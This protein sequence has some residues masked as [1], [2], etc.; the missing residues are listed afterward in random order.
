MLFPSTP[1]QGDVIEAM[2]GHTFTSVTKGNYY[3]DEHGDDDAIF[4]KSPLMDVTFFHEQDCCEQV[5]IKDICGDLEDLE[6][7]PVLM[8]ECIDVQQEWQDG[9]RVTSSWYKFAT[10][11]GYVT[12]C[13]KGES[14]GWYCER[15]NMWIEEKGASDEPQS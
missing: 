10:V 4:F 8:A 11:K 6:G 12:V 7:S 3:K 14:N 2:I 15:V 13:W 9:D 5:F 1:E